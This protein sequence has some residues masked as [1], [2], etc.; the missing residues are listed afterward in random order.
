MKKWALEWKFEYKIFYSNK[1]RVVLRCVGDNCSLRMR[2]T[3]LLV[4]IFFVVKKY[5]HEHKCDTTHRNTN[6]TLA[7]AKAI[8]EAG[9]SFIASVPICKENQEGNHEHVQ[10]LPKIT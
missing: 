2:A 7:S 5:V 10:K 1:S 6:H 9:V 3:K 4:Q 8:I